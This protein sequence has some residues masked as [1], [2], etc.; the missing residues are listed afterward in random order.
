MSKEE[1]ARLIFGSGA[2][3]AESAVIHLN[4]S[5]SIAVCLETRWSDIKAK[6]DIDIKYTRNRRSE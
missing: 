4:F 5:A 3:H 6:D 2:W 1:E